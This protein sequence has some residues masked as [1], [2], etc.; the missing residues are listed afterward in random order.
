M[1]LDISIEYDACFEEFTGGNVLRIINGPLH[2]SYHTEKGKE[3]LDSCGVVTTGIHKRTIIPNKLG[4][5]ILSIMRE[6]AISGTQGGFYWEDLQHTKHL[7][8]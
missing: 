4:K 1:F 7:G 2:V 6:H 5:Y 8:E 3:F